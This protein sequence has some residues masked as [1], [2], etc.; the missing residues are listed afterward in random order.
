[1]RKILNSKSAAGLIEAL[2]ATLI[3]VFA[4]G[5][6]LS[7]TAYARSVLI[8]AQNL[9][10]AIEFSKALTERLLTSD[11]AGLDNTT[12]ADPDLP[13]ASALRTQYNGTRTYNVTERLW[14]GTAASPGD[15]KDITVTTTYS[16]EPFPVIVSTIMRRQ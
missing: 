7:F 11:Y 13:A 6:A 10:Q 3:L 9:N 14:N 5:A 15:Y 16:N 4:S 1:M 2:T 12:I 8:K